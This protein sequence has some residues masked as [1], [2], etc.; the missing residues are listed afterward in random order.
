MDKNLKTVCSLA[1]WYTCDLEIRSRSST[2]CELLDPELSHN[3]AMF[4]RPPLNNVHQ[5]ANVKVFVKTENISVIILECVQKS[6][7]VVYSLSTWIT[8]QSYKLKFN[9][10]RVHI[11]YLKLF[12]T[13]ATL[14]SDQGKWKVVWTCKAQWAVSSCKVW[15]LSYSWCLSKYQC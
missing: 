14:K 15:C 9:W 5:K 7:I 2:W 11:F 12:N 8:S 4:E 6:K 10:V 13:A 3:R 1:F